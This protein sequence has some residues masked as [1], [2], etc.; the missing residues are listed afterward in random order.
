MASSDQERNCTIPTSESCNS[1]TTS[2]ES[3]QGIVTLTKSSKCTAALPESTKDS[4]TL[5]EGSK[6]N[7]TFVEDNK[8]INTLPESRKCV[9][10]LPENSNGNNTLLE[11]SK[12]IGT[13]S[14]SSKGIDTLP[15]SKKSVISLPESSQGITTLK[16]SRKGMTTLQ[17]SCNI[18]NTLPES[19][20]SINILPESSKGIDNLPESRKSVISLPE[21]SKGIDTLPES[22]KS[23]I[24]LPESSNNIDTLP[25]RRKSVIS[26]PESSNGIDTLPE[27]RKSVISL[28]ESSQSITIIQESSKGFNTVPESSNAFNT[29]PKSYEGCNTLPKSS[30]DI[31]TLPEGSISVISLPESNQSITTLQ[32]S[33]KGYNTLPES[34]NDFNTIPKSYDD[35]NTLPK[36]SKDID[37]LLESSKSV[38]SLPENSKGIDALRE[39]RKSVI[40]LLESAI[41]LPESSKSIDTLPESSKGIDTLPESRKSVINS[42]ESAISLPEGSNGID[43]LPES[44]KSVIRLPESSQGITTLQE[45]SNAFNTIPK[46]YDGRNTL[47]K[48]SKDIDTLPEGSKSA[49]SLPENSKGIDTL[50]ESRKSVMSLQ[51]NVISLPKSSKSIDTFPESRK[52]DISLPKISKDITLPESSSSVNTLPKSGK[53]VATPENGNSINTLPRSRKDIDT[54]PK[55]SKFSNTFSGKR[56]GINTLPEKR[57]CIKT[58]PESSNSTYTLPEKRKGTKILPTPTVLPTFPIPRYWFPENSQP[59]CAYGDSQADDLLKSCTGELR[60]SVLALGC[61]GIR[62][63]LY[64]L[65]KHFDFSISDAPKRFHGVEFTLNDCSVAVQARN[66][67]LLYMCLKLPR[68]EEARRKW[69][70]AMWAIWYC[71]DLFSD[72]QNVLNESLAYL[73]KISNPVEKWYSKRN[74]M[75]DLVK[76]T[77]LSCLAK[78]AQVWKMWFNKAVSVSSVEQMHMSRKAVF[79]QNNVTDNMDRFCNIISN[80]ERFIYGH[81]SGDLTYHQEEVRMYI[82][83]GDCFAEMVLELSDTMQARI[84]VN[85]TLYERQDGEYNFNFGALPF[86]AYYHTVKFSPQFL[87]SIG[88]SPVPCDIT[89]LSKYFKTRPFLANSVQQF[90]MWVQSTN[91]ALLDNDIHISFSFNTRDA[92][93][94]C[95]ELQQNKKIDGGAIRR[96]MPKFSVIDTSDLIDKLGLPNVV[97][98]AIP[99]VKDGGLI[100]TSTYACKTYFNTTE[101]FLSMCCGFNCELFPVILGARCVNHEGSSFSSSTLI[102]PTPPTFASTTKRYRHEEILIWEKVSGSQGLIFPQL[103]PVVSGSISKALLDIVLS[104]TCTL[105][106]HVKSNLI[107][108]RKSAETAVLIM[109]QFISL[110][111]ISCSNF[112]FWEPLCSSLLKENNI[113]PFLHGLQTQMLLHH[114]HVHLTV[115]QRDCPLCRQVPLDCSIVLLCAQVPLHLVQSCSAHHIMAMFHK[116]SSSDASYLLNEARSGRDV[117]IFDCLDGSVERNSLQMKFFAPMILL[118]E[119]YKIVI[120]LIS[121]KPEVAVSI[122]IIPSG[123]ITGLHP[124]VA[125]YEFQKPDYSILPQQSSLGQIYYH[126]SDGYSSETRIVLGKSTFDALSTHSLRSVQLSASDLLISCSSHSLLLKYCYPISYNTVDMKFLESYK[127]V[128][129]SCYRQAHKF[130]EESPCFVV[131]PD[132]YFS[133][134]QVELSRDVIAA[135]SRRQFASAVARSI[136]SFNL[137]PIISVK[138]NLK[139]LFEG[140]KVCLYFHLLSP[141]MQSLGYIIVNKTLFDYQYRTPALDLAFC[142]LNDRG[143]SKI[144]SKKWKE[145]VHP[146]NILTTNKI[147]LDDPE[148]EVLQNTLCYFERRTNGDL[149][150][151]GRQSQFRLL[152]RY[153]VEKFFTRAVV[154]FLL[155]DPNT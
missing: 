99:L 35:C 91:R 64:T 139:L 153:K 77:S 134:L 1:P 43:T 44:K 72:H 66:I 34:N 41:S 19:Y 48:S 9:I 103:P 93:S 36:S 52:S 148:L 29:L 86:S 119:N 61:G 115:T 6:G 57:K 98:S 94:F 116:K 92:L 126:I 117:H 47:P 3:D 15:E 46:S 97:L 154:Y 71:H 31:D 5:L 151:A 26:L 56:K 136:G 76:F 17:E 75:R 105:I 90:T 65:W 27:R 7:T 132:H 109:I 128:I 102:K 135:H 112:S 104:C 88:R 82:T 100:F 150:S 70:C 2:A 21:S 138:Q 20:E 63:C 89:V 78:I 120:A 122:V 123:A 140:S 121:Y 24:S 73:L 60:P 85:F 95:Q 80:G 106:R 49:I 22:R 87:I 45:S 13:L 53:T 113:Q 38:I 32:E 107:L 81:E 143:S 58:L 59:Y 10:S 68:M 54:L 141:G 133:L 30:K 125:H 23:V 33:S 145:L 28:P 55:S 12:G 69:L 25:E 96:E 14:E 142:F 84:G 118:E 114:I 79:Q 131:S 83:S 50:P 42:P 144:V 111:G 101:E 108:S 62:S 129:I 146:T 124:S 39:S 8:D 149:R 40:S 67:M 152:Y 147:F 51:K 130:E 110:C 37:T 137:P 127:E 11:S 18:L 74:P 4:N 155:S 16:E